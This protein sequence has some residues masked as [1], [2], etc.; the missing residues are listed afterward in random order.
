MKVDDRPEPPKDLLTSKLVWDKDLEDSLVGWILTYPDRATEVVG[1]G[2]EPGHF[3]GFVARTTMQAVLSLVRANQTPHLQAVRQELQRLG[4]DGVKALDLSRLSDA[5]PISKV[6][7]DVAR[8]VRDAS[9]RRALYYALEDTRGKLAS[10]SFDD[11]RASLYETLDTAEDAARPLEADSFES[12]MADVWDHYRG[13]QES[14]IKT[15]LAGLD[16]VTRGIQR[17]KYVLVGARTSVGKTALAVSLAIP[18]AKAG[19]KISFISAEMDRAS[20]GQRYVGVAADVPVVGLSSG[21]LDEAEETRFAEATV[22]NL[23]IATDDTAQTVAEVRSRAMQHRRLLGGLDI[24]IV[25][26]LQLL[27]DTDDDDD[28]K[29]HL[30]VGRISRGLKRI[31]KSMNVIV[32]ALAQLGRDAERKREPTLKDLRES[33]NLEQDADQ[34][35]LLWRDERSKPAKIWLKVAK[36]RQGPLARVELAYR[37]TATKF[38]EAQPPELAGF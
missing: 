18:W 29:R 28:D 12:I 14:M 2:I 38:V 25:D 16:R 24:I 19:L 23:S 13:G 3:H 10:E 5:A 21:E 32:I 36:N 34:V 1:A 37:A 15:G 17:G 20:I 30:T 7:D 22:L 11:I 8:R 26:Y 33:G 6:W 31:A 35:W 4:L 9:R 27:S